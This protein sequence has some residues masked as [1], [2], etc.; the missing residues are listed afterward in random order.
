MGKDEEVRKLK[1]L[2]FKILKELGVFYKWKKNLVIQHDI[3]TIEKK[4][5]LLKF[6]SRGIID[7]SL[8][9]SDTIEGHNYWEEIDNKFRKIYDIEINKINIK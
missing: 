7:N 8:Y 1:R 3:A 5:K 9:W 6:F 4:F 2:V